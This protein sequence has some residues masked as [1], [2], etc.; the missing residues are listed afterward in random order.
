[1]LVRVWRWVR[2]GRPHFLVGGFVMHAL[3]AA[4]A[5][6]AGGDI[7]GRLY[8]AGQIAVTAIQWMTHYANEY[9][10]LAA[11]TAN[12]TP[13]HW[14]G[15]SR[16]LP[17]GQLPPCAALVTVLFFAAMAVA[18][19]LYAMLALRAGPLA[20]P[21]IVLALLW[22]WSYSAPPLRLAA[23]G[24]GEATVALLVPGMTALVGF[25]LQAGYIFWPL[26]VPV[27]APLCAL[28]F[29]M[30]LSINFPD[31]RGDRAAG[32][33]TLVVRLGPRRAAQLYALSI[34][35]AYALLLRH[36]LAGWPTLVLALP[37]LSLPLGALLGWRMLRGDWARPERWNRLAFGS[38]ALLVGSMIVETL[39]LV[40]LR[41][42][43]WSSV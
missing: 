6:Y 29:A 32:K 21:L 8:I 13:T 22:A 14:S 16:V 31:A 33:R 7:D 9:F 1:M 39:A 41:V 35:A 18:A 4:L 25:Y 37:L 27:V 10:D 5:V 23:R 12:L 24:L 20:L 28:Q 36:V 17:N 15:G 2:L 43:F 3:G 11:D 42:R 26:I 40:Y 19:A 34:A 38:I 30:S